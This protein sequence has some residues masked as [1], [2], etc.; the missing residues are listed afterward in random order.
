MMKVSA[1][2]YLQ[3][4]PYN[5]LVTGAT[6]FIGSQLIR[7]IVENGYTVRAMS[8]KDKTD[9]K[10]IKFVKADAL[11]YDSL[12][13]SMKETEIAYYLLHSMEGDTKHWKE[14]TMREKTQAQNFIKA[15]NVVGVKRIIYLGGL[16]NSST[17]LSAHMKSRKEVGD[18]LSSTKIPVTKLHASVIIGS[19]SGSYLMLKYLVE[20]LPIMVCPKWIK[21]KTQP[22]SLRNVIDYL[23]G[24]LENKQT[25][26]KSFDIGGKEIVT[27]EQLMRKHASSINKTI[28]ILNVPILTPRLSS[29]WVNLVTPV[30][31]SLARPLVESLIHDSVVHNNKIHEILPIHLNT[32]DVA[33]NEAKVEN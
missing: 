25:I 16:V 15:A 22:I 26:G 27:Y 28:R 6:G 1:S 31:A 21:S 33:L 8:R 13:N 4:K 32:I 19:S 14:F 24:C 11:D 23:V 17:N 2:V 7:R 30:K 12:V 9:S 20:R 3:T 5:I 18:I 10:Q 29:Y